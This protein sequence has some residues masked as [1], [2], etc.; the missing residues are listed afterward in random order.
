MTPRGVYRRFI[1]R[2]GKPDQ[3]MALIYTR[4]S[5][6][7]Y[8]QA[9]IVRQLH[10]PKVL[11]KLPPDK[12]LVGGYHLDPSYS[13]DELLESYEDPKKRAE[14]ESIIEILRREGFHYPE[15]EGSPDNDPMAYLPVDGK[16]TSSAEFKEGMKTWEKKMA[17]SG[18]RK[19]RRA[20]NKRDRKRRRKGGR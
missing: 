1:M 6:E 5:A 18:A 9:E 10:D 17:E 11:E 16:S 7:I 20:K 12:T 4:C 13:P 3:G 19:K 14:L 15:I 2:V 8:A